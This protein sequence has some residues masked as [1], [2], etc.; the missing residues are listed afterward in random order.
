MKLI[1]GLGNPGI[2]YKNSRHNLGFEIVS[3]LSQREGLSFKR[4]AYTDSLVAKGDGFILV[5][6]QTFMNL[7]GL[8]VKALF[9]KLKLDPKDLLVVFDDIALELG[10]LK[11]LA[12]GSSGGHQ[13]MNS[14]IESLDSKNFARLR[15]GTGIERK[16]IPLSDFVLANFTRL[17]QKLLKP[18][19][20]KAADCCYDWINNGNTYCMNKYNKKGLKDE[21]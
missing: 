14:I 21:K 8:S 20:E 5:L 12:Q 13:G 18:V 9:K 6:P 19:I 4:D 2:K 16:R 15:V 1:V 10:N 7:S 11:V 17:E 3:S